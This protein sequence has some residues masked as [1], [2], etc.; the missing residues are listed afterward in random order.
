MCHWQELNVLLHV[1]VSLAG[2][3]NGLLN[4]WGKVEAGVRDL[5]RVMSQPTASSSSTE[6]AAAA[7]LANGGGE[8]AA[9]AA[10]EEGCEA[11]GS[12]HGDEDGGEAAGSSHRSAI[13]FDA[14]LDSVLGDSTKDERLKDAVVEPLSCEVD[15][16]CSSRFIEAVEDEVRAGCVAV[17]PPWWALGRDL[18]VDEERAARRGSGRLWEA[19]QLSSADFCPCGAAGGPLWHSLSDGA[20]RVEGRDRGAAGA[21]PGR[22]LMAGDHAQVQVPTHSQEGLQL[23][24]PRRIG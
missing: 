1:P 2:L 4:E 18:G 9:A 23:G 7:A 15:Y 21:P 12:S 5:E 6:A 16:I 10:G 24:R 8:G 22:G 11:A 20:R 3:S 17:L 19:V 14:I 13:P